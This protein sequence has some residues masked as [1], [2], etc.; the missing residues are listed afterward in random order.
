[1]DVTSEFLG[2][3]PRLQQARQAGEGIQRQ[4][5]TIYGDRKLI[6]GP[7]FA[8]A[9][10]IESRTGAKVVRSNVMLS[11]GRSTN[12]RIVAYTYG[13]R[14]DDGDSDL[15]LAEHGGCTGRALQAKMPIVADL[16]DARSSYKASW[17]MSLAQQSKVPI[18][19]KSMMSI[20]IFAWSR[21]TS[22]RPDALPVLGVLSVDSSTPL[23]ETGWFRQDAPTHEAQLNKEVLEIMKSWSDVLSKLLR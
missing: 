6:E 15:E 7:L 4:L 19:R 14:P 1:M 16:V 20:P 12:S 17:G 23:A 2:N 8:V 5:W 10:M 13:Y 21:D 3:W 18:D 11:T 22:K 9:N